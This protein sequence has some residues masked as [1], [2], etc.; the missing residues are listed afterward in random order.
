MYIT[1]YI[2]I[3]IYIN[4]GVTQH[5]SSVCDFQVFTWKQKHVKPIVSHLSTVINGTI[6]HHCFINILHIYTHIYIYIYTY[7][8]TLVTLSTEIGRHFATMLIN[9]RR[10]LFIM[11]NEYAH[12]V[13][14]GDF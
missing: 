10:S 2:Y 4:L 8:Y 11:L 13:K 3:Y 5:V 9:S 14:D 12:R 7:T 6:S 1:I